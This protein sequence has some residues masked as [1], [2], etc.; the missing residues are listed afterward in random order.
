MSIPQLLHLGNVQH[1]S[2]AG[3]PAQGPV[4]EKQLLQLIAQVRSLGEQAAK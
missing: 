4:T 2:A 3:R 1:L